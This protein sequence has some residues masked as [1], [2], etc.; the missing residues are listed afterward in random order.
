MRDEDGSSPRPAPL[1]LPA[2]G[3]RR[4]REHA[5]AAW[6]H[7]ACGLLVR[8]GPDA[9]AGRL[10]VQPCRNLAPDPEHAYVID[11]ELFLRL[12]RLAGRLGGGVIGTWHSHPHGDPRPS[13][14]DAREAWPGWSYVIMG[15]SADAMT[16][17]RA[18]WRTATAWVEQPIDMVACTAD[19]FTVP[20]PPG[21][22]WQ[23]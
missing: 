20:V 5:R 22:E 21:Q 3:W 18:W 23:T 2:S 16:P 10:R 13:A 6:P 7:E 19:D 9:R 15:V 14:R 12:D 1:R 17:P 11:P 8:P 4:M